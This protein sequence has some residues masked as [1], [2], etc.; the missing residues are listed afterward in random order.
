MISL[1][2]K[3]SL[4]FI[5]SLLIF[6]SILYSQS[7][8]L[9]LDSCTHFADLPPS[10]FP[11]IMAAEYPGVNNGNCTPSSDCYNDFYKLQSSYIPYL[12]S[13]KIVMKSIKVL[14]HVVGPVTGPQY[15]YRN[16][17]T[18]IAKINSLVNATNGILA[19][20]SVPWDSLDALCGDCYIKDSRFRIEPLRLKEDSTKLD[21]RFHNSELLFNNLY[22]AG[23]TGYAA[24]SAAL[25]DYLVDEGNVLNVFLI[26]SPGG[27]LTGIA[28]GSSRSNH[29]ITGRNN[30]IQSLAMGA[31]WTLDEGNMQLG[32]QVF[33]HELGHL[34]GIHHVFQDEPCSESAFDYLED[35]YG[36]TASGTKAGRS[37]PITKFSENNN[38]MNYGA[39]R[40][41]ISPLQLGRIHWNAQFLSCR[42]YIYNIYPEDWQHSHTGE[43]QLHPIEITRNET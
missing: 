2:L 28:F 17:P 5:A 10:G 27:P 22:G 25:N 41:Y 20:L 37:C 40:W 4:F 33:V 34:L 32:A 8:T 1:K 13:N 7:Y 12:D 14:F 30:L 6:P 31:I 38:V 43:G 3:Q 21:I 39:W 15:N 9:D 19:D 11:T 42:K 35:V 29:M 16:N 18:D 23:S 26:G 36:T 24:Y